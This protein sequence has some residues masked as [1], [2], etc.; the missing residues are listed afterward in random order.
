MAKLVLKNAS[1]KLNTVDLSDHV[2]SLTFHVAKDGPD[3]TA[4]GDTWAE[5]LAST[6]HADASVEFFQDFAAAEVD[7]TAYTAFLE[8][9]GVEVKF[10]PEGTVGSATNP[11]YHGTAHIMEYT[12]ITGSHGD[13][14]MAP[15]S[16]TFT[17]AI[18]R[19]VT[20]VW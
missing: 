19:A 5:L 2:K 8:T 16:L 20:A 14:A 6:L 10:C 9:A 15:L 7:A 11:I 1:V 17:G 18:T 3:A 13:M 4:M 12:P